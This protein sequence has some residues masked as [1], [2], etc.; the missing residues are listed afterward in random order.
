MQRLAHILW[1]LK[2]INSF[3]LKWIVLKYVHINLT[4]MLDYISIYFH[5]I[6]RFKRRISLIVRVYVILNNG[7][8]RHSLNNLLSVWFSNIP[9][10]AELLLLLLLFERQLKLK[11]VKSC[12]YMLKE[13][14]LLGVGY[15]M[16]LLKNVLLSN[17]VLLLLIFT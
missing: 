2:V 11:L 3:D 9:Q 5:T 14:F 12:F 7:V 6:T 17:T 10:I 8:L 15:I 16:P 1:Y 4:I 13:W